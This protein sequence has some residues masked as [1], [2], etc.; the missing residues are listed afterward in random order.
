MRQLCP[1]FCLNWVSYFVIAT[2]IRTTEL[3]KF[4]LTLKIFKMPTFPI[5]LPPTIWYKYL[6][7]L[8]HFQHLNNYLNDKTQR[9]TLY[10]FTSYSLHCPVQFLSYLSP[11]SIF[12]V[13]FQIFIIMLFFFESISFKEIEMNV[14]KMWNHWDDS[15]MPDTCALNAG[16]CF[17]KNLSKTKKNPCFSFHWIHAEIPYKMREVQI[18]EK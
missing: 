3:E 11:A 7:H 12:R 2:H 5:C 14:K 1:L 10:I 8:W 6:Y 13:I 9:V 15:Q 17:L 16:P 4:I 18:S